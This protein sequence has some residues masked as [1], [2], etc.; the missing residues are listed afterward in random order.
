MKKYWY[1]LFILSTSIIYLL[2]EANYIA[3][4]DNINIFGLSVYGSMSLI[5]MLSLFIVQKIVSIKEVYFYLSAG[6]SFAYVSLFVRTVEAIH[7]YPLEKVYIFE[8]L[9][10]LV[11]FGF[12]VA[13]IIK[14]IKH[15]EEIKVRL[16]ELA[17]IDDL[18]GIMNRR[19]FDIEFKRDFANAK[20]YNKSLSLVTIDIDNFKAVNDKHGHFFGDL[21][22]RLF[23]KEVTELLRE[24]DIFSRWGG[25]EFCIILPET[26]GV[27]A[28]KVAEKIRFAVKNIH[29]KTDKSPIY[30]TVSLGVTE[31][32]TED[33]DAMIMID[34][35]D[36]A[37]YDAKAAGR[38]KTVPR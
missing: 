18:T 31:F 16:L 5:M 12:V 10:R 3:T 11:G 34:R 1:P 7:I 25:D 19:V 35:A 13:A 6:F 38:D 17:S 28:M 30:F 24:G 23:S 29:V 21:V 4:H 33:K 2:L 26:S 20:R 9:F 22:L 14:W 15:D 36:K 8:D 27:N 37:L 32:K